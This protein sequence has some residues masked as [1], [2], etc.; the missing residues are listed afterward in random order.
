MGITVATTIKDLFTGLM[1]TMASG[2]LIII[3]RRRLS[4]RRHRPRVFVSFSR[5]FLF[6]H[7]GT[8]S[9][10]LPQVETELSRAAGTSDAFKEKYS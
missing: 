9:C 5:P 7:N 4:M 3:H 2:N 10:R 1:V 8:V 6:A